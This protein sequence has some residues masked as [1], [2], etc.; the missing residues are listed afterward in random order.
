MEKQIIKC[1]SCGNEFELKHSH[2]NLGFKK[3]ECPKCKQN[4]VTELTTGY[5]VFYLLLLL[6]LVGTGISSIIDGGFP[7]VRGIFSILISLIFFKDFSI[8][9]SGGQNTKKTGKV[10]FIVVGVIV[11]LIVLSFIMQG[12]P[13][14]FNEEQ[15]KYIGNWQGD[16]IILVI[17]NDAYIN[18]QKQK[19]S[20][21]TSVSGPIVEISDND[22][23]VG[24]GFMKSTFEINKKPYQDGNLWKM[25]VDGNELSRVTNSYELKIPEVGEL[26]KL[27]NDF[28]TLF[29]NSIYKDDYQIFYDGISK[30]WQAQTNTDELKKLLASA[31]KN[32][33]DLEKIIINEIVYSKPPFL[34]QNNLLVLEGYYTGEVKLSFSLK[35]IYEYPN[36]KLVGFNF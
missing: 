28:F 6:V 7:V 3:Y 23:K 24:I 20:V 12:D 27:T 16:G 14:K 25:T 32:K 22:F 11:A 29:N 10:G 17:R 31:T 15:K 33:I 19:E 18:Y 5:K 35:F 36:W 9:K 21:S 4:F 8:K 34:D 1:I 2:S 26:N 13:V 30:T